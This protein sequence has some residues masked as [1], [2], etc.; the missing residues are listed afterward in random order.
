[1]TPSQAALG[2][3]PDPTPTSTEVQAIRNLV[4]DVTA[5]QDWLTASAG[6][7]GDGTIA[8][9]AQCA[10]LGQGAYT[11]Q[12]LVSAPGSQP[13]IVDVSLRVSADGPSPVVFVP[14]IADR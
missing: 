3:C 10:E 7:T 12:L 2:A 13:R 6:G 5:S 4:W 14:V 8:V 1:M 11:G 9:V